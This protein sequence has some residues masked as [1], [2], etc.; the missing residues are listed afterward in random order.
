[1]EIAGFCCIEDCISKIEILASM[2]I[3]FLGHGFYW[4][5][6][7]RFEIRGAVVLM[8]LLTV[9]KDLVVAPSFCCRDLFLSI[10]LLFLILA[11]VVWTFISLTL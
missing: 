7:V 3:F 5:Y 8:A 9:S 2:M 1:M 10:H 11:L 4:I 6:A